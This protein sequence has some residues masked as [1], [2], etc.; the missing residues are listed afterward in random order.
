MKEFEVTED[1]LKLVRS[2]YIGWE[3][4]CYEGAPAVGVKRPYGNSDVVEDVIEI[5]GWD[6]P[7]TDDNYDIPED[8]YD[9]AM[10]IHRETERVLQ[11]L[12]ENLSIQP[13]V[14]E[15]SSPYSSK[16]WTL[17]EIE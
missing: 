15:N 3:D 10:S 16:G 14:Y 8:L 2:F 13:G 5:L 6:D 9:R 1:H 7:R 12:T 17:R 11:I 4:S